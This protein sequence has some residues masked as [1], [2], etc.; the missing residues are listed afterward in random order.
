M[1]QLFAPSIEA[2]VL[3]YSYQE[4]L[5]DGEN[6]MRVKFYLSGS[7]RKGTV[8]VDVKQVTQNQAA[9]TSDKTICYS[10]ELTQTTIHCQRL[11]LSALMLIACEYSRLSFAPTTRW[12]YSQA[13]MLIHCLVT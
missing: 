7:K 5:V 9:S 10:S 12:L 8:H 1:F 2:L 11:T 3:H 4:Y 6:Y 13:M